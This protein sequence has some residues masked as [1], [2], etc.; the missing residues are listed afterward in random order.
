MSQMTFVT[1]KQLRQLRSMAHFHFLVELLDK[2]NRED[3]HPL[4]PLQIVYDEARVRAKNAENLISK[5]YKS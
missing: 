4:I 5:K 3:H 1:T 2:I